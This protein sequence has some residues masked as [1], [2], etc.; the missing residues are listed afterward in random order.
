MA[1]VAFSQQLTYLLILEV[2]L[3]FLDNVKKTARIDIMGSI[4]GGSSSVLTQI[5]SSKF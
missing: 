5:C 3:Y 2:V 1:W 4:H